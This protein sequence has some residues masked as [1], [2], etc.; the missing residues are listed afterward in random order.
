MTKFQLSK[1]HD[2][3]FTIIPYDAECKNLDAVKT[4]E[5]YPLGLINEIKEYCNKIDLHITYYKK[6]VDYYNQTAYEILTNELAPILP[7]FTKQEREK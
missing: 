3:E 5:N 7:T 4:K 6:Q 1:A 2:L